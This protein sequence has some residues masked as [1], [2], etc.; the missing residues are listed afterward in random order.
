MIINRNIF[1]IGFNSSLPHNTILIKPKVDIKVVSIFTINVDAKRIE[2]LSKP[3]EIDSSTSIRYESIFSGKIWIEVEGTYVNELTLDDLMIVEVSLAKY[4]TRGEYLSNENKVSF[5]KYISP[6]WEI[7]N[8]KDVLIDADLGIRVLDRY[9]NVIYNETIP[10]SLNDDG[11]LV[12]YARNGSF[13]YLPVEPIPE[14]IEILM[15][16]DYTKEFELD[17]QKVIIDIPN[18]T[19]CYIIYKPK[20]IETGA[21]TKVSENVSIN[22]NGEIKLREDN[23]DTILF[24]YT[25]KVY[26]TDLTSTN[27]TPIIKSLGIVS[28]S[29]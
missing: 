5:H 4:F 19:D 29:K 11:Y 25:V 3:I 18:D 16:G 12:E 10:I 6:I 20:Y 26:N 2:L 9:N 13:V 23:C 1:S 27:H 22:S 14:S 7:D 21:F 8:I 24:T 15:E 28:S 17:N